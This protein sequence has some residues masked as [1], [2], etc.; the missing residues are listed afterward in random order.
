VPLGLSKSY[1]SS[2]YISTKLILSVDSLNFCDWI[3]M[4][5]KQDTMVLGTIPIVG[6]MPLVVKSFLMIPIFEFCSPIMVCVFPLPVWPY[7]ITE[8]L[9]PFK[10]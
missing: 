9:N 5:S 3:L 2:F 7:M 8:A 6:S 4:Y 10:N 1:T